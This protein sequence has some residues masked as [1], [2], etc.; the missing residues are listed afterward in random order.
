MMMSVEQSVEWVARETEVLGETCPSAA[1][2]T[3]NPTWTDLDSN[4]VSHFGK[5]ATDR[6]ELWHGLKPI[7]ALASLLRLGLPSDL[8]LSGSIDLVNLRTLLYIHPAA[9][10][11][12][13]WFPLPLLQ[14][15][16]RWVHL[17]QI[18]WIL[19]V[20]VFRSRLC[21]SKRSGPYAWISVLWLLF[22]PRASVAVRTSRGHASITVYAQV[23]LWTEIA[24]SIFVFVSY[25]NKTN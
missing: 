18:L 21:T 25:G 24:I 14:L 12:V 2:Y 13:H 22:R 5:L 20:V 6:P 9:W 1:L 3:T 8:F 11:F 15:L 10:H 23:L 7:L 4:P 16:Y 17:S 19:V